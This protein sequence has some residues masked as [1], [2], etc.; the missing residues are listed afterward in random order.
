MK[1]RRFRWVVAGM[2]CFGGGGLCGRR[3]HAGHGGATGGAPFATGGMWASSGVGGV[4]L[5][6]GGVLSGLGGVAPG[7]CAAGPVSCGGFRVTLAVNGAHCGMCNAACMPGGACVGGVPDKPV[8][9]GAARAPRGLTACGAV[10]DRGDIADTGS[11]AILI[12]NCYNVTI[13]SE[14]G[15]VAIAENACGVNDPAID[16]TPASAVNMCN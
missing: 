2:A 10:A 12:E 3:K 15:T 14:S 7:A 8:A 5:G 1:F 9:E 13:A 6:S 11:N 16:V 4:G